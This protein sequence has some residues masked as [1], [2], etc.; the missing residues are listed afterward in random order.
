MGRNGSSHS[1]RARA[2]GRERGRTE[3]NATR[4]RQIV[5]FATSRS[6]LEYHD[7]SLDGLALDE[8]RLDDFVDIFDG[9]GLVPDP[10]RVHDQKGAR[11]AKAEAASPNRGDARELAR[12]D[13]RRESL[14]KRLSSFGGSAAAGMRRGTLLIATERVVAKD[15]GQL[16][17]FVS[18][19]ISASS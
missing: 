12:L 4:A 19:G 6:A 1:A 11:V 10:L 9:L 17:G 15:D 5:R 7:Q 8:V 14:P 16:I 3:R 13:H 2:F 18:H